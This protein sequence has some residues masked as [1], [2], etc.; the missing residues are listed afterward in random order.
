MLLQIYHTNDVH[1]D[2][3]FLSRV[4][5]YLAAHRGGAGLLF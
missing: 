2:F 1:A 3:G 5:A 4:Y